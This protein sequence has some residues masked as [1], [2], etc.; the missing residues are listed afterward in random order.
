MTFDFDTMLNY[1]LSQKLKLIGR[2]KFNHLIISLTL[3]R[4]ISKIEFCSQDVAQSTRTLLIKWMLLIRIP[5]PILCGH[6]KKKKV[7]LNFIR[8]SV[9]DK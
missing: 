2:G 4:H 6:V 3:Y 9:E 5:L 8:L 1:K 7:K